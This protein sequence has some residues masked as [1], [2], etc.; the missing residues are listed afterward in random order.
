MPSSARTWKFRHRRG[1]FVG[2]RF[3]P[4]SFKELAYYFTETRA[5]IITAR[6]TKEMQELCPLY[7]RAKVIDGILWGLG[8]NSAAEA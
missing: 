7:T 2:G 3:S 1:D 8:R 4:K 5:D 6:M